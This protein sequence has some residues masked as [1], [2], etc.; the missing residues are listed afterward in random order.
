MTDTGTA[1]DEA[2]PAGKPKKQSSFWR[3]L[4]ILLVIALGLALLIKAFLV[5]AFYI[6]SESMLDTLKVNDRVLVNK[7][8]YDF[9]DVRRGEVIVF[10]ASNNLAKNGTEQ[11]RVQAGSGPFARVQ[12]FF[13]FGAPGEND[14]IKRVIGI[15]G[16][17]VACCDA[18]GRVTVQPEGGA[19]VALNEQS[20]LFPG[21]VPRNKPFCEEGRGGPALPGR[22][23][24]VPR[25]RGSLLRHG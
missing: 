15:P 24:G 3:E 16:D 19:P 22:R 8:V 10:D 11:D 13:G 7:L 2:T 9:R 14:Y 4:P 23:P 18:E 21:D 6:P 1:T 12:Q 5:Q 20:Y 17:R 25:A